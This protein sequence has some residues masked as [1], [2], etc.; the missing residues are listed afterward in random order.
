MTSRIGLLNADLVRELR[1]IRLRKTLD[2]TI[3][4]RLHSIEVTVFLPNVRQSDI[5]VYVFDD[6]LAILTKRRIGKGSSRGFEQAIELPDAVTHIGA[7][8]VFKDST[9][10]VLLL[11]RDSFLDHGGRGRCLLPR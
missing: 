9:L 6:V 8:L 3:K 5:E 4:E 2:V 10:H 1:D 11:R 7:D